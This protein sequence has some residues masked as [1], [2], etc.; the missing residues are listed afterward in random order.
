MYVGVNWD[1]DWRVG[2]FP[3]ARW[4]IKDSEDVRRYVGVLEDTHIDGRGDGSARLKCRLL[5]IHS[6][7]EKAFSCQRKGMEG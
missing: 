4:N 5:N 6:T 1:Q 3:F 2:G 7:T